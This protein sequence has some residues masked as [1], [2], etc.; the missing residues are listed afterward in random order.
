MGKRN[1]TQLT[2]PLDK[3]IKLIITDADLSS[4]A[5]GSSIVNPVLFLIHTTRKQLL[6]HQM[7]REP[8]P[9]C[10][11]SLYKTGQGHKADQLSHLND[12]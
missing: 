1:P 10:L 5:L 12:I 9:I 2:S 8:F 7:Y 3:D 11:H 6:K 4:A